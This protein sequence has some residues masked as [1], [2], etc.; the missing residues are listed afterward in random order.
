V[1]LEA[2]LAARERTAAAPA[3]RWLEE[4]GFED[5]RLRRLAAQLK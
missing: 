3:L 4:S 2:A 1:L 5:A